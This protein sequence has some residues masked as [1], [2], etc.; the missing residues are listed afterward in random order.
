MNLKDIKGVIGEK[1]PV[2]P[3]LMAQLSGRK[4]KLAGV[5][6]AAIALIA[7]IVELM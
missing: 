7:A 1:L 3:T 6:A 4:G 2:K 5:I